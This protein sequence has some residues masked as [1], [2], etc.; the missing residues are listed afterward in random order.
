M[1][2]EKENDADEEFLDDQRDF[3]GRK[4]SGLDRRAGSR[5]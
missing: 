1:D 3:L 5:P 2:E 4:S